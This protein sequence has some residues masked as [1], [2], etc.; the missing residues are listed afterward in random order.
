[1]HRNWLVLIVLRSLPLQRGTQ[2]APCV[3]NF[4]YGLLQIVRFHVDAGGGAEGNNRPAPYS[5]TRPLFRVFM[6]RPVS[7][8]YLRF[9]RYGCF[10]RFLILL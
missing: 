1:M 7:V 5:M 2:L 10:F 8:W 9:I 3:Q 6:V 4:A